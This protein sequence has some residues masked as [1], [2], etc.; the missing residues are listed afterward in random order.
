MGFFLK[1]K[2]IK[3]LLNALEKSCLLFCQFYQICERNSVVPTTSKISQGWLKAA[4]DILPVKISRDCRLSFM[5]NYKPLPRNVGKDICWIPSKTAASPLACYND[6]VTL[7]NYIQH[8]LGIKLLYLALL[9]SKSTFYFRLH[10]NRPRAKLRTVALLY[11]FQ[12]SIGSW[13][14]WEVLSKK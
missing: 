5:T 8:Y 2:D 1:K 14:F 4:S 6:I 13:G 12:N 11:Y 7:Y 9:N 10:S 3:K